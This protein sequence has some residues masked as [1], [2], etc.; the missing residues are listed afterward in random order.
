MV[1]DLPAVQSAAGWSAVSVSA[2]PS[3]AR[4]QSDCASASQQYRWRREP[5]RHV[6]VHGEFAALRWVGEFSEFTIRLPRSR[7]GIHTSRDDEEAREPRGKVLPP[8]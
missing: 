5:P 6:L 8:P 4:V 7:Y 3:G 2:V 1:F